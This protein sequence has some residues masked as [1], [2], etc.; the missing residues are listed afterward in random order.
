MTRFF[1]I[2]FLEIYSMS[3]FAAQMTYYVGA[4]T[5]TNQSDNSTTQS[6]YIIA[7]TVDQAAGTI[8]EAAVTKHDNG[9]A[10]YTSTMS[11]VDN[12]LSMTESTGEITGQGIL[13]GEPWNWSFL[14]AEFSMMTPK[15]TLRIVD[16]NI[17]AETGSIL[18]HKD[19]YMTFSKSAEERLVQ[20]E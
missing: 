4:A 10:E 16:Y 8:T 12:T 5:Q 13:I 9:Y 2:L 14:K 6:Q 19:F 1:L 18:G 11:I 20:Q 15:Y 17:F 3:V 7:R